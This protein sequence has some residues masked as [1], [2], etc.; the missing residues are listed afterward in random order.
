MSVRENG[1]SIEVTLKN[2]ACSAVVNVWQMR[3]R[4]QL[5]RSGTMSSGLRYNRD[6]FGESQS[7]ERLSNAGDVAPRLALKS[8]YAS[9][10]TAFGS[11]HEFSQRGLFPRPEVRSGPAER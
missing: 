4:K 9:K 7:A 10:T 1:S 6:G 8:A 2:E 3:M 5:H 11:K